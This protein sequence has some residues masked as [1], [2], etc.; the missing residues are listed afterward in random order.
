MYVFLNYRE[1]FDGPIYVLSA[2]AMWAA[3]LERKR[4]LHSTYLSGKYDFLFAFDLKWFCC[5][6]T[7][8]DSQNNFLK[9]SQFKS[10]QR[11]SCTISLYSHVAIKDKYVHI[12]FCLTYCLS[13]KLSAWWKIEG[14]HWKKL[15]KPNIEMV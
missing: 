6:R 7:L 8:L 1:V 2:K 15:M 5:R 9:P 11:V 12:S 14:R 3:A 4:K 13:R 10:N